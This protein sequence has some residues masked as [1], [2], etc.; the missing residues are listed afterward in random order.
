MEKFFEADTL[1]EEEILQGLRKGLLNRDVFPLLVSAATKNIGSYRI[2]DF[3][4][5]NVPAP[6]QIG[7]RTTVDGE[8]E[9]TCKADDPT[10]LFIYKTSKE[11]HLGE[12][13]FFKVFGGEV[14]EGMDLISSNKGTKERLSQIMLMNGKNRDKVEKLYAGDFGAAIKLKDVKTNTTL[15]EAKNNIGAL[16]PIVFPEPFHIIAIN[17]VNSSDDE[18]MGLAINEMHKVDP[19]LQ[20]EFSRELKQTLVKAYGELHIKTMKW[21]LDNEYK[22]ETEIFSPKIAY[23]ETI[24]KSAKADYRHK[25]QSG[26]SGQFGE[27]HMLI[28]PYIEGMEDQT[29][30]PVRKQEVY[31]LEWGGKLILNNCIVGGS[32]DAKYF[33][34]I[35]KGLMERM[36]EGP[37]TGSYARD[38]VVNV[39]DGKMHPVDSN[40]ISFK[41]AARH[42]FSTAFK[43]AGPKIMEPVYLVEVLVPED[44]MGDTMTDL[45]GRRAIIE[46]ME[47]Q[48]K[49]QLL[50]AKVPLAEMDRYATA[51]SSITSGKG[52]YTMVYD[53]YQ[54]VP[55]DVQTELLKKYEAEQEEE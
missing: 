26:G 40:E 2:L 37:L 28:E 22:I 15:C 55:G 19:T 54:P 36:E 4:A 17:P 13:S 53:S 34:A 45:Q 27:V 6:D 11:H 14:V 21:Y 42:A 32:I 51:L 30:F 47:G 38:I 41:L 9:L 48:G 35:Y 49:Y 44:K 52:E 24:T 5:N 31:E 12:V 39:Y 43:Q 46:G 3:I 25:K 10:A 50:K 8:K 7:S 33:P 18:K 16:E 29:E 20:I 23:R 1:T